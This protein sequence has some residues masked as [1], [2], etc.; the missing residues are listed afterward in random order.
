MLLVGTDDEVQKRAREGGVHDIHNVDGGIHAAPD[1]DGAISLRAT[2]EM[3]F[4]IPKLSC[5][6]I[7]QLNA[8]GV[9]QGRYRHPSP[10]LAT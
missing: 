4:G 1:G 2:W 6:S 7:H 9:S 8:V 5:Q 10:L 3:A